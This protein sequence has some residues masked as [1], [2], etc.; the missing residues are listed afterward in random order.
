MHYF[1]S[2]LFREEQTLLLLNESAQWTGQL[3]V[4][5]PYF[6]YAFSGLHFELS[7]A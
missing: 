7:E 6:F 4:S 5:L 2:F 1:F 3:A